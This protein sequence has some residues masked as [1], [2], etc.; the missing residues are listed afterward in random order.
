MK[1]LTESEK[2][3]CELHGVECAHGR[4][5]IG[6]ILADRDRYRI[7]LKDAVETI[8]GEFCGTSGHHPVCDRP[9]KALLN[10]PTT[11]KSDE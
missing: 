10:A 3:C 8:H 7:A 6:D 1:E 5:L 9:R 11:A 2:R 4:N